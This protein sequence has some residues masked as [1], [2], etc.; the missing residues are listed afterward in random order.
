MPL[1]T[2]AF[3]TALPLEFEAVVAHLPTKQPKMFGNRIYTLGEKNGYQIV[4]R[5]QYSQGNYQS[6]RETEWLIQHFQPAYLFFVGVAGGIKEVS[7]GE[8]VIAT[9]A[10]GYESVKV[11]DGV[12]YPRLHDEYSEHSA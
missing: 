10:R 3:L 4:V 2:I 7:L 6:A 9:T 1:P 11:K 5:Q 12:V 8:I